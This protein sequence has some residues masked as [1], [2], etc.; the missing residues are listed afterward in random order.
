MTRRGRRKAVWPWMVAFG[1]VLAGGIGFYAVRQNRTPVEAEPALQTTTVRRGDIVITAVGDGTLQPAAEVALGF[2]SGGVLAAVLVRPGEPVAAGQALARVDDGD[3]TRQLRQARIALEL[4]ELKLADLQSGPTAAERAAAEEGLRAAELALARLVAGPTETTLAIAEADLAKSKAALAKAQAAYDTVSWRPEISS[5]PQS[6]ALEQATFDY[7]KALATYE[8]QT[9]GA[10][11]DTVAAARAK[12]ATARQQLEA[13]TGGPTE[14]AL[15]TAT[16]QVEQARLS[17]QQAEGVLEATTLR[18]PMDGVVTGIKA[19]VGESVGAA[20]I[21]T[22]ADL[23][24][25]QVRF[26]LEEG[27][28]DKA[29]IGNRARLTFDAYPDLVFEGLLARVDPALVTVQNVPAVQAWVTLTRTA[30]MPMLLAGLSA[31]VEI[32]AGEAYRT[33]LV[34]VQALREVAPGQF[35]VFVVSADGSLRL[36]PVQVGLRNFANAEILSGLE[37]GDVVSTGT[38]EAP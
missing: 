29:T 20:S 23:E 38:V 6:L 33:L 15:R 5:L 31:E 25:A 17:L 8:N 10:S 4:A 30:E 2:K 36:T 14:V 32:V 24:H 13:L 1:L 9:A 18:A 11:G 26:Y 16:L 3:A 35:A 22:L 34:P 19:A 21:I 12:V 27:D 7:Q 37:S 28:L